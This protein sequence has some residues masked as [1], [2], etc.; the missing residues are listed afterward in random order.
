MLA[1]TD[2][3]PPL[4]HA[5]AHAVATTMTALLWHGDAALVQQLF[6]KLAA[7][8]AAGVDPATAAWIYT[9]Q[10]WRAL[11]DGDMVGAL[12]FDQ[13]VEHCFTE[14]GDLRQACRQH[15]SV[16]YGHIMLGANA[17]AEKSLRESIAI[18][19]KIGLHQVTAVA[20]QNLGVA[21]VRIGKIDEAR[22]AERAA[23]VACEAQQNIRH[24]ASARN[25]LAEIELAA[26]NADAALN[27]AREAIALDS[28]RP[29]FH[30]VYRARIASAHLLA[31]DTAAALDEATQ[32]MQL[33]DTHGRPEEGEMAVRLAYARALHGSGDIDNARVVIADTVQRITAIAARI[34]DPALRQSFLDAVPEHALALS[35]AKAWGPEVAS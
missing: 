7:I 34:G 32:A 26:G 15:A 31:G 29:G 10:A 28:E 9:A 11:H 16:G 12:E 1:A 6:D 24:A 14:V 2:V 8:E 17:E 18:A 33:M 19:T 30:C 3:T 5:Y 23:L 20:Q 25:Y 22:E 4:Y 21:L 27:Y 13:K 35:L